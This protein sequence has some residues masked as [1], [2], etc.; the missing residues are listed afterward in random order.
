[1]STVRDE[2]VREICASHGND[3]I[4]LLDVVRAIDH[5]FHCIDG[6][7]MNSIAEALHI[8][9]ADVEGVVSFYSFLSTRPRGRIVIRLCDDVVD[10]MKGADEVAAE[11]ERALGTGSARRLPTGGSRSRRP[12]VSA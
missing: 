7:A 10:K 5:R 12:P 2:A 6:D 4:Q 3:A 11:F 8:T 1:M 9:R